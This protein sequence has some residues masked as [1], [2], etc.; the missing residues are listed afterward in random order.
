MD[1]SFLNFALIA[2]L[3]MPSI[4]S[5]DSGMYF[6]GDPS[7]KP[8]P[9]L[10]E[11]KAL[12]DDLPAQSRS[13]R[14]MRLAQGQAWRTSV[15]PKFNQ[16]INGENLPAPAVDPG[17]CRKYSTPLPTVTIS[18]D[19]T[20]RV[21][22]AD[23]TLRATDS[24]A[25]IMAEPTRV[26]ESTDLSYWDLFRTDLLDLPEE[27][28]GLSAT[29][30]T[31]ASVWDSF[32]DE[33]IATVEPEVTEYDLCM[34]QEATK[35][36]ETKQGASIEKITQLLVDLLKEPALNIKGY[37]QAAESYQT[38][39]TTIYLNGRLMASPQEGTGCMNLNLL[40]ARLLTSTQFPEFWNFDSASLS[41]KYGLKPLI[42][43]ISCLSD[44]EVIRLVSAFANA[45]QITTAVVASTQ[46]QKAAEIRNAVATDYLPLMIALFDRTKAAGPSNPLYKMLLEYRKAQGYKQ[47]YGIPYLLMLNPA[48]QKHEEVKVCGGPEITGVSAYLTDL[49]GYSP[50]PGSITQNMMKGWIEIYNDQYK[51]GKGPKTIYGAPISELDLLSE[52]LTT[53]VWITDDM[54]PNQVAPPCVYLPNFLTQFL[55]PMPLGDGTCP[56]WDTARLGKIC[57]YKPVPTT[58]S[59][60]SPIEKK[61]FDQLT[62]LIESWILPSA[63]AEEPPA[64][65]CINFDENTGKWVMG[66]CAPD[67]PCP[68]GYETDMYGKPT[69]QC[70]ICPSSSGSIPA[71]AKLGCDKICKYRYG[72]NYGGGSESVVP[73]IGCHLTTPLVESDNVSNI[74][75]QNSDDCAVAKGVK[76]Q[77][78]NPSKYDSCLEQLSCCGNGIVED[79]ETCDDGNGITTD[80]CSN[81]CTYGTDCKTACNYGYG[82]VATKTLKKIV[83]ART[84]LHPV[85]RWL[86]TALFFQSNSCKLPNTVSDGTVVLEQGKPCKEVMAPL[87]Q[88]VQK[89]QAQCI[90]QC[91]V[92]NP[93]LPPPASQKAAGCYAACAPEKMAECKASKQ[94]Y[95]KMQEPGC[96]LANG[97][98]KGEKVFCSPGAPC[99]CG[100]NFVLEPCKQIVAACKADCADK[101]DG[102]L[103]NDEMGEIC[104][105]WSQSQSIDPHTSAMNWFQ[106]TTSTE[107]DVEQHSKSQTLQDALQAA[108]EGGAKKLDAVFGMMMDWIDYD[109]FSALSAEDR[110]LVKG[111]AQYA[112]SKMSTCDGFR[113]KYS[114]TKVKGTVDA[115]G[116][117]VPYAIIGPA[118][119]QVAYEY[120]KYQPFTI[121]KQYYNEFD[122][123]LVAFDYWAKAEGGGVEK[124]VET[125]ALNSPGLDE[126]D[127]PADVVKK[128]LIPADV[129]ATAWSMKMRNFY[130]VAEKVVPNLKIF[131]VLSRASLLGDFADMG[132]DTPIKP[133]FEM[134]EQLQLCVNPEGLTQMSAEDLAKLGL[135]QAMVAAMQFQ[136]WVRHDKLD[137]VRFDDIVDS[138]ITASVVSKLGEL[139]IKIPKSESDPS[140]MTTVCDTYFS[141]GS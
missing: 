26:V 50:G 111:A 84:N 25:T 112:L 14:R 86:G 5:G 118:V 141:S 134:A 35:D 33:A 90:K 89:E 16:I 61:D 100:W 13:A 64:P 93:A 67:Q 51:K 123:D 54:T 19:S 70:K 82:G 46:P 92:D 38:A 36:L 3:L 20:I 129:G 117:L 124:V 22:E 75:V 119:A 122:V 57:D 125:Y 138:S 83:D 85:Y 102:T 48:T 45:W 69:K 71:D 110:A 91:K 60:S 65:K 113:A 98:K 55:H 44:G 56:A 21:T 4:A 9:Y 114:E 66:P 136:D 39:L 53:P 127:L 87:M 132:G 133:E 128:A 28:V 24:S 97:V 80:L 17:R 137:A 49:W 68:C 115:S 47:D 23:S 34:M 18:T 107:K 96:T 108:K 32:R 104:S 10:L 63:H 78:L 11:A 41:H 37:V 106:E 30:F 120:D 74:V 140:M 116:V 94:Y 121:L 130:T 12:I 95:A 72:M 40:D 77:T 58:V 101:Y 73:G 109:N 88:L 15:V 27:R 126:I 99:I 81:F 105:D 29:E 103:H 135:Q 2:V 62:Q 79:G 131:A 7:N 139:G 52:T 1:R 42:M 31:D 76:S 8:H 6:G 43:Q 59:Q